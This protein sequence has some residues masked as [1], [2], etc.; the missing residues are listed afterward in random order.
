MSS[1]IYW[2]FLRDVGEDFE[3]T[4]MQEQYVRDPLRRKDVPLTP[5]ERVRQWFISVLHNEAAV[6]MHMMMSEVGFKYGEGPVRKEFRADIVVY[7][8]RPS[9]VMLVECKRPDTVLDKSV[10][11]QAL[12]YDMVLDVKYIV[13]TN[14]IHTYICEKGCDG[15]AV[16]LGKLPAYEEMLKC[17]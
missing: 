1:V 15:K 5:E 8:R 4:E 3:L 9:P 14:G 6:P 11:E 17:R 12:R 2:V 10:A 16:F 13:I 7:D